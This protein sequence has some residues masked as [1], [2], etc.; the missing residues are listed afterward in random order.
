MV[1]ALPSNTSGVG[2]VSA[3]GVGVYAEIPHALQPKNRNIKQKLYCN[4]LNKVLLKGPHPKKSIK[5][6]ESKQV[7]VHYRL[8]LTTSYHYYG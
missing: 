8:F 3:G 6:K 7:K 1:K 2:S 4:T 5:N